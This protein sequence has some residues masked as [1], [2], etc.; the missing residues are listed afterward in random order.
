LAELSAEDEEEQPPV[1]KRYVVNDTTIEKL[2]EV[3][4]DNPKGVLIFRDE[5]MGF[6]R[7]MD[8]EGH[9][10]DRAFYLKA[11]NGTGSFTYDR[12]GRGTINIDA[13]C[14]SL[15]GGIQPGPLTSYMEATARGGG[16]DD[17]LMQRLQLLVWPDVDPEWRNVD[18]EPDERARRAARSVFE[19]V[20]AL[21][22]AF[23][24]SPERALTK[25]TK[26]TLSG[27][28]LVRQGHGVVAYAVVDRPYRWRGV[29]SSFCGARPAANR[30]GPDVQLA[31]T[32]RRC[33]SQAPAFG[34]A[35]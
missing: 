20:A 25:L 9:E 1:R 22:E 27:A 11:W 6:L 23:P 16:G 28:K 26:P 34:Q 7:Q 12:I 4:S 31:H 24:N 32:G 33:A 19:R 15:S 3:L 21:G 17:G 18:R 14:V 8:R 13:C 2:G 35:A 5:L 29:H 10:Q 30:G